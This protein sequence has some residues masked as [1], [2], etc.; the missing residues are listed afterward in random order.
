MFGF[1]LLLKNFIIIEIIFRCLQVIVSYLGTRV[2]QDENFNSSEFLPAR[3]QFSVHNIHVWYDF[4]S[5]FPSLSNSSNLR[6]NGQFCEKLRAKEENVCHLRTLDVPYTDLIYT[7]FHHRHHC[8]Q[9]KCTYLM[10]RK[11]FIEQFCS[12]RF[13]FSLFYILQ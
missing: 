13:C 12:K 11:K 1:Y 7:N 4:D 10:M 8:R 9:I 3:L 6:A 5:F 2:V